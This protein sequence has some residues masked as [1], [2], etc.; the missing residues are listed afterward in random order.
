MSCVGVYQ[1]V[2]ECDFFL[3]FGFEDGMWELIV[4]IR[5]HYLS[6]HFLKSAVGPI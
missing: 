4:L 3:F 2:S 6:F 1:F 5:D